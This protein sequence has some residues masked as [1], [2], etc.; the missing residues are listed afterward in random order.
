MI[1]RRLWSV[2]LLT[3][4]C[5]S[6]AASASRDIIDR[7]L[8]VV[9]RSIITRSDVAA[10]MRLGLGRLPNMPAPDSEAA[11]LQRQIERRLMMSEV[12][13]YAPPEP[14]P[15]DIDRRLADIRRSFRS[16]AELQAVLDQVGLTA[17]RLRRIVRDD[18][19]LETYLEQR[20]GGALQPSEEDLVAYYQAHLDRFSTGGVPRP[21]ANAHDDVRAALV[22]E[23]RATQI[24]NWIAGLR[25]R[26]D[27]SIL[28]PDAR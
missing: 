6:G 4:I 28:V 3:S 20:F 21:F 14:I 24:A 7:V 12:E 19:R 15:A 9:D 8:A 26:A 13:R 17:E 10:S 2:V 18:L 16:D 11:A 23:R 25:R 27:I 5:A 1:A 22:A